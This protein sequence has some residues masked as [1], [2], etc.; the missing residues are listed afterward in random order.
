L[1]D[2]DPKKTRGWPIAFHHSRRLG[3]E[4]IW[5]FH[6]DSLRKSSNLEMTLFFVAKMGGF[7]KE[8]Q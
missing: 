6:C 1:V 8:K 2:G 7:S 3:C 5:E 4:V